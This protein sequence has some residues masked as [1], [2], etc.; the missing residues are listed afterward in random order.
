[1]NKKADYLKEM[2][3]E[4]RYQKLLEDTEMKESIAESL[5][6]PSK[7]LDEPIEDEAISSGEETKEEKPVIDEEM[8]TLLKSALG[9]DQ[10]DF[11]VLE[12][13]A[14]VVDVF[15]AFAQRL[16][17]VQNQLKER[18]SELE[19][20]EEELKESQKDSD[21]R[22]ADFLN[23]SIFNKSAVKKARASERDDTEVDEKELDEK[24][25]KPEHENFWLS[26]VTGTE[27][28]PVPPTEN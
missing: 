4:D 16:D 11:S 10:V 21:E 26:E 23:N 1:M 20:R 8:T 5:G 6:I 17:D 13:M 7:E 3:G 12:K 28:V 22:L 18:D 14:V 25:K 15:P 2:L 19:K 24:F 27:P 9:L